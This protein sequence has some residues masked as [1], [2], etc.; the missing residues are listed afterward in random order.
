MKN[1]N[2]GFG[3]TCLNFMTSGF[4]IALVQCIF[5]IVMKGLKKERKKRMK[6]IDM[7]KDLSSISVVFQIWQS[8]MISVYLGPLG[9][10]FRIDISKYTIT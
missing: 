8:L 4:I 6:E 10:Y 9:K 1:I 2:S 7:M 3:T 5:S